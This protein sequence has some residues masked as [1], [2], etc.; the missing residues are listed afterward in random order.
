MRNKCLMHSGKNRKVRN[1]MSM[2]TVFLM[3]ALSTDKEKVLMYCCQFTTQRLCGDGK[4]I[5]LCILTK[6]AHC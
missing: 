5:I 3:L 2:S 4:M 6:D 1:F